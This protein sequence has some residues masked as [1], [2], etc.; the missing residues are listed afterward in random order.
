MSLRKRVSF[1]LLLYCTIAALAVGFVQYFVAQDYLYNNVR[2]QSQILSLAVAKAINGDVHASL[3][4]KGLRAIADPWYVRYFEY[5][6]KLKRLYPIQSAANIFTIHYDAGNSLWRYVL[7]DGIMPQDGV[8]LK[9]QDIA[10][11]VHC[12]PEGQLRIVYGF[13]TNTSDFNAR[14]NDKIIPIH[15]EGEAPRQ[16]LFVLGKKILEVKE[17]SPH[18]VMDTVLGE[19]SRDSRELF[20][21]VEIQG[22]PI[23]AA[24]AFCAQ[25][26]SQSQPGMVF[27]RYPA[28]Y[29]ICKEILDK[30]QDVTIM[31][32]L[33]NIWG[34]EDFIAVSPICTDD[35]VP[36]G[37][38]CYEVFEPIFVAFQNKLFRSM[39]AIAIPIIMLAFVLSYFQ[40]QRLVRPV[41][42]LEQAFKSIVQ[43]DFSTRI[44]LGSIDEYAELAAS[45]NLM[46]SRHA[47]YVEESKKNAAN[48]REME[49]ARSIQE[50]LIPKDIPVSPFYNIACRYSPLHTVGGD[51]ICFRRGNENRIGI[52]VSDVAGH[53]L[54]AALISSMVHIAFDFEF[55]RAF[56]A[57]DLL[58][59]LNQSLFSKCVG[60]K[61]VTACYAHLDFGRH[62]FFVANAGHPPLI[63]YRSD[64]DVFEFIKP[65]GIP[66]GCFA[67]AQY[68][69]EVRNLQ[70]GDR[71]ILYT[72]GISEARRGDGQLFSVSRFL[73]VVR[74]NAA[75]SADNFADRV[76]WEARTWRDAKDSIEDDMT[77]VV[78]DI[79]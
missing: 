77:I 46:T 63:V 40:G 33:E 8:W 3:A 18:L 78:V 27:V 67:D 75:L 68:E 76:L 48:M 20:G 72:D 24:M 59:G 54:S 29:E 30:N 6:R 62:R 25:G 10:L 37:L 35:G 17:Y 26:E 52:L 53:G 23:T 34:N 73:E 70:T 50:S 14:V 44:S 39:A 74:E 16:S 7:D 28:F 65:K 51:S 21:E 69:S 13:L 60:E 47:D 5:I 15:F 2:D 49:L 32:N 11:D 57:S 41:L 55:P 9:M 66:V 61:Y 56:R 22:R 1:F 45:F 12:T 42:N 71:I 38:V 64:R 79:A 31:D 19:M 4:E 43:G 58:V 36:N